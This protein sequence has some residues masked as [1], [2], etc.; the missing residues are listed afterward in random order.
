MHTKAVRVFVEAVLRWG[1][2]VSFA[3]F[4]IQPTKTTKVRTELAKIYAD[5]SG[6]G[7][8]GPAT[9]STTNEGDEDADAFFPYV[10][11]PFVLN[12]GSK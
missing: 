2:P 6:A 10:Y 5:V 3:S 12:L 9:G 1:L 7:H 8:S 11:F 4:V